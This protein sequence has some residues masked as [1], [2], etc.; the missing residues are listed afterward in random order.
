MY[1]IA[2]LGNPGAKYEKNRHNV[3]FLVMD[4]LVDHFSLT[5][6]KN[7]YKS[8]LY[9]GEIEGEKIIL[10]KPQTFMNNSGQAIAEAAKFF[11]IPNDHVLVFYDELDLEPGKL[12]AKKGGG[13]AGHNGIRSIDAHLGNDFWRFRIGIGHPGQKELVHGYVLSDFYKKDEAWLEPLKKS[14]AK[15]FPLM[16]DNKIDSAMSKIN[17]DV[18]AALKTTNT[19]S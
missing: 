16:L 13:A 18:I 10:L 12:R 9:D 6:P 2:G 11:K 1:L 7:K 3:G 8:A 15:H 14:I 19:P 5:G 17:Q 4:A